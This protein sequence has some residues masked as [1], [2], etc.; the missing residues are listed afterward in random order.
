MPPPST[1]SCKDFMRDI[2]ITLD[3]DATERDNPVA[4]FMNCLIDFNAAL[5][6]DR[7]KVDRRPTPADPAT[8]DCEVKL[9][10]GRVCTNVLLVY[11]TVMKVQFALP[12]DW[13][14]AQI[15]YCLSCCEAA[16]G[17]QRILGLKKIDAKYS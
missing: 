3:K 6:L 10:D 8:F 9:K 2:T 16:I 7:Y 4:A 1:V 12:G 11:A 13:T 5:P 15:R 17:L 14:P